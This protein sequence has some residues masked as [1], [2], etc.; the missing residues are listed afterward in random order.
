MTGLVLGHTDLPDLRW[1]VVEACLQCCGGLTLR[2]HANGVLVGVSV[3]GLLAGHADLPDL[4]W[5]VVEACYCNV[6]RACDVW[7]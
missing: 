3:A 1:P 5:P 4:R 6:V 7:F 2:L